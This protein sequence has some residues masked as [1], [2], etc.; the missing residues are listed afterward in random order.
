MEETNDAQPEAD[1]ASTNLESSSDTKSSRFI[2]GV[3][4]YDGSAFSGSQRQNN[5]RSVQG[6]LEGVLRE[7]LKHEAPISLA[8][9]TD[10]GV[11]AT[12]QVFRFAT[13]NRIPAERVALALNAKLQRDIRVLWARELSEEFHPRFSATGRV[14]RYHLADGEQENPL[15]RNIAGRSRERLDVEAM[16]VAARPLIGRQDFAAWQSAGSPTSSSVREVRRIEIT[17]AASTW[18]SSPFAP[19]STCGLIVI[20]IEAD[21][22]L[23]QMV[24]NIV[25]AL[26]AAGRGELDEAG[27]KRLTLEGDR[28][29]C[30]P[31]A[32]PQGLCLVQVKYNGFD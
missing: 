20:E 1:A 28:R 13:S 30:P 15:L 31:P 3:V 4:A 21:G 27:V 32:P 14:Y 26:M 19:A 25:G 5:G 18:E 23:Y 29:K 17:R 12:G 16:K 24:R 7:V 22:F 8:G 10:A 2:A 9:R 6:D 11:H